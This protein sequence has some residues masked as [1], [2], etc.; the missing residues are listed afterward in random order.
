MNWGGVQTFN[1]QQIFICFKIYNSMIFSKLIKLCNH[2]HNPGLEHFSHTKI[3]PCP[4]CSHPCSHIQPQ[5]TT[6]ILYISIDLPFLDIL[7][8]WNDT[9]VMHLVSLRF[10]H[11]VACISFLLLYTA[12]S[13]LLYSYNYHI[14]V[15]SSLVDRHLDCFCFGL[16]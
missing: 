15:I 3:I 5:A 6:N 7:Y 13:V 2:S 1:V 8:E 11:S 9:C 12:D 14:M 4:I 16:L 10:I